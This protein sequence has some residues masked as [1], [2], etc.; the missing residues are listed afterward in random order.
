MGI[1]QRVGFDPVAAPP[2]GIIASHDFED[3]TLGPFTGGIYTVPIDDPTPRAQG[4]VCRV[5][6]LVTSPT[7]GSIDRNFD[8]AVPTPGYNTPGTS[9]FM[10]ADLYV[11]TPPDPASGAMRKL[12]YMNASNGFAGSANLVLRLQ[13]Y[14][15]GTGKQNINMEVQPDF[16]GTSFLTGTLEQF[17]YDEWNHWEIECALNS[18]VDVADG[19]LR[20][21][22]N[23]ILIYEKLNN[24]PWLRSTVTNTNGIRTASWGDQYQD[25]VPTDEYRY[26]DNVA[27]STVRVGP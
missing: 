19:D 23:G 21:Y 5:H 11:P 8:W 9:I 10:S 25:D 13:S 6:Y 24:F 4:K 26:F 12:F 16:D 17:N 18:A 1:I 27:I 3:G 15:A 22:K 20:V 2:A 14:N 7:G